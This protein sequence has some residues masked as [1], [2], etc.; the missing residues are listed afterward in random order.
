MHH[1]SLRVLSYH[2][3]RVSSEA[4]K[5]DKK[6]FD[7][8]VIFVISDDF[9]LKCLLSV[10]HIKML[11]CKVNE[12]SV[13]KILTLLIVILLAIKQLTIKIINCSEII[14]SNTYTIK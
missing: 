9:V 4:I 12:A 10:I 8:N 3:L 2:F 7:N 13:I 5:K 6:S 1:Y 14:V 11:I